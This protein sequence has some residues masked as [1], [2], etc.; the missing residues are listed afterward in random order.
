MA[1]VDQFTDIGG[2]LIGKIMYGSIAVFSILILG[3]IILGAGLYIRYLRQFN[4]KVRIKSKRSSGV[5]GNPIYKIIYD[6][7]AFIRKKKEKANW[8]RIK[9]EKVDLC[10]PPFETMQVLAN[11]GNE[12]EILKNSD[13][14][15]SYLLPST[16][17]QKVIVREGKQISVSEIDMKIVEGDIAYWNQLR[18]R[19]N[20]EL[21]DMESLL[22]KFLPYIVPTLMVVMV[23]FLTY[24]ITDHWGEFTAA[25]QALNNAA[26]ALERATGA[27]IVTSA[28]TG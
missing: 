10:N 13:E 21:F 2:D 28:G 18:K 24:I 17:N 1:N 7:G 11:G 12:I 5:D 15:Y 19:R 16:S 22:M 9:G 3:G 14:E 27:N 20:K 23:I 4:I 25:A 26:Q 8:F 6:K